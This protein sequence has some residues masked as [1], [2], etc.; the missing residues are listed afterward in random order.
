MTVNEI[1]KKYALTEVEEDGL[2]KM[3]SMMMVLKKYENLKE[4][5]KK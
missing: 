5:T 3:I 1:V 4:V 2:R